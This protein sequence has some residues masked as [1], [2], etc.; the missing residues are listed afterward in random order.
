MINPKFPKFLGQQRWPKNNR[1]TYKKLILYHNVYKI[2][3]IYTH[4]FTTFEYYL[5]L[6]W[7]WTKLNTYRQKLIEKLREIGQNWT[8][9]QIS[10]IKGDSQINP[11]DWPKRH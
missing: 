11:T 1:Y 9:F 3:Y 2:F 8:K 7:T 10:W 5:P 6:F 4:K